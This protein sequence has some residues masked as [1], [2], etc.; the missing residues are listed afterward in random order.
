MKKLFIAVPVAAALMVTAAYAGFSDN[1]ARPDYVAAAVAT[2]NNFLKY[3]WGPGKC[4]AA[5]A[6]QQWNLVCSYN[7]GNDVMKYNVHPLNADL[8][9]NQG[10]FWL[11]AT[12][13]LAT[14]SARQGL[15][16]Y[17]DIRTQAL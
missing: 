15:S 10:K 3:S 7:N 2:T 4:V 8:K 9:Q 6:Q 13:K 5:E 14:A 16:R 11:E 1:S 12:N 17:L